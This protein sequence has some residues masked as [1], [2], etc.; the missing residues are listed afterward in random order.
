MVELFG[1]EPNC[2]SGIIFSVLVREMNFFN[3]IFSNIL[4]RVWNKIIGR[5]EV[6]FLGDL[7]GFG[8][9]IISENSIFLRLV[10]ITGNADSKKCVIIFL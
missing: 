2:V 3:K 7:L 8:I 4:D 1:L 10:T 9:N 5:F 6:T